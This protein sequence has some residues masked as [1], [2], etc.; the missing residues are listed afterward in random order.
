MI[1]FLTQSAQH[2][3]PLFLNREAGV[4][5]FQT[6]QL[7]DGE[8]SVRL[9]EDVRRKPVTL[10]GSVFPDPG[11]LFDVLASFR[12]LR[13]NRSL[14]PSLIVPYLGYARQDRAARGGEAALGIM[15]AEL[16]RNLNPTSIAVVDAHS[17][18]SLDALGPNAVELSAIPLF[19][20][21][22]ADEPTDV[23]VAPDEGARGRAEA[24]AALLGAEVAV[25][26]KVRPKPNVAQAKSV[27][28]EVAGRHA[29]IVDDL[30][31]T[32]GTVIEAVRMVSKRGATSIRVAAT[33]GIFSREAREKLTA[34]PIR[35]L[36]VTNTLPQPRHANITVVDVTPLLL[37]V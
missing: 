31:D 5:T 22:L 2:L 21:V 14:N 36:Y 12:A 26:E 11:S 13:E 34:L 1:H 16:L 20:Q 24:L 6:A 25:I 10:V 19:A 29:V 28:G 37:S 32:G 15:V 18:A 8:W 4:G 7:A 23:V 27:E 33:H 3:R 30:I 35:R 9:T 17:R